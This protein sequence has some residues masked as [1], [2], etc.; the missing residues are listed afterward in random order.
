MNLV[1]LI[2][3]VV[4]LVALVFA[5]AAT[6]W[7]IKRARRGMR[8][9]AR[10]GI[11]AVP[12][13]ELKRILLQLNNQQHPF[14]LDTS[15]KTDLAIE[16]RVADARWIELLGRASEKL[17]YQAWILLDEPTQTVKY[18]EQLLET[19]L[20]A[21]GAGGAFSQSHSSSGFEL[22]G[23]RTARRWGVRPDFSV[24]EV[25]NYDFTPADVKDLIRQIAND[26]GW[27]FELVSRK[28]LAK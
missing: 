13:S 16:W 23:R 2:G 1:V 6:A 11:A 12:K 15:P 20:V 18:W 4:G 26:H 14:R 21:G 9:A 5:V 17:T 28:R 8:S 25:L 22:W 24:G 10:S 19:K 3:V 27:N 7:A